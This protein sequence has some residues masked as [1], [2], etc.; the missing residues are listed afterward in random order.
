MSAAR[1][2]S[3]ELVQL[4]RRHILA[5]LQGKGFELSE[6][7]KHTHLS[8]R[9]KQGKK[10]GFSTQVS[11]GGKYKELGDTLVATM[12]EQCGLTKAQFVEL[13]ECSMSWDDYNLV[14]G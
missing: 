2:H 11:R 12:A 8:Y 10:L 5:S 4:R 14:V 7:A 9:D 3:G 1:L 13:V 6:G